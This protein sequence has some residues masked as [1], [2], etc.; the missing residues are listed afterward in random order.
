MTPAASRSPSLD[1]AWI[2]AHI[3]HSGAMCLL[4]RVDAWDGTRI[5]CTATSHR[6]PRN[7]LRA[8]GRLASVCG[9]E[10]AAQAMAVHGELLGATQARPRIGYLASV[11]AVDAHVERLDTVDEPLSIEAER[12]SGD[13]HTLLYSFTVRSGECVL[14]TGRATVVLDASAAG[15]PDGR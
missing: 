11:R 2:A 3:P 9:I 10:Y 8:H 14:L 6:D 4:D 13:D 1:R 5:R 7:P 12:V 15:L